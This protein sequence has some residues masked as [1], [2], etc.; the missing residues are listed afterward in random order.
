MKKHRSSN[1]RRQYCVLTSGRLTSHA[2]A[3]GNRDHP[4]ID[5]RTPSLSPDTLTEI[6]MEPEGEIEIDIEVDDKRDGEED[7]ENHGNYVRLST[8]QNA[9]TASGL[10]TTPMGFNSRTNCTSNTLVPSSTTPSLNSSPTSSA[11][12]KGPTWAV[13]PPDPPPSPCPK[14]RTALAP[15]FARGL[16]QASGPFTPTATSSSSSIRGRIEENLDVAAS[17]DSE[18]VGKQEGNQQSPTDDADDEDDESIDVISMKVDEP[19]G[20]QEQEREREHST[21]R[22][23]PNPTQALKAPEN[24]QVGGP[25]E[26]P[27][28][29]GDAAIDEAKEQ[30][31]TPDTSPRRSP[32]TSSFLAHLSPFRKLS[33]AAPCEDTTRSPSSCQ[34]LQ[35]SNLST[36]NSTDQRPLAHRHDAPSSGLGTENLDVGT[37]P[38]TPSP[39]PPRGLRA[40]LAD[41]S[42]G[43]TESL[44]RLIR[45]ASRVLA[46][47][48]EST[49][50]PPPKHSI[51]HGATPNEKQLGTLIPGRHVNPLASQVRSGASDD[52]QVG[53]AGSH[54]N[55]SD[56]HSALRADTDHIAPPL[57]VHKATPIDT[58]EGV[59]D[60]KPSGGYPSTNDHDENMVI[61]NDREVPLARVV[62]DHHEDF[63]FQGQ[64]QPT[65]ARQDRSVSNAGDKKDKTGAKTDVKA[66]PGDA[67]Q[68]AFGHASAKEMLDLVAQ[69]LITC[70]T[71]SRALTVYFGKAQQDLQSQ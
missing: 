12:R 38:S 35:Q 32:T 6:D 29:K 58:D 65:E 52:R 28:A 50:C 36:T 23:E 17:I 18:E 54:L 70:P 21:E 33:R 48:R 39:S 43:S 24:E 62:G 37:A 26:A 53:E 3:S 46:G 42:G 27:R 68:L 10:P 2:S 60:Q 67:Q 30:H 63:C 45:C 34:N 41:I 40:S 59:K 51:G 9:T 4:I 69:H 56:T 47:T 25:G 16:T 20:Q 61:D 57:P 13:A 55:H 19:S 44:D 1:L 5:L 71:L 8:P 7:E 31:R 14:P 66:L 15:A 64:N 22:A 49:P 11:G